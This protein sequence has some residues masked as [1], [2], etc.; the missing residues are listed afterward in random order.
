[1]NYLLQLL[2]LIDIYVILALSLNLLVGYTGLLSLSQAAFYGIGAY[3]SAILML[4]LGMGFPMAL[5]SAVI[6][7]VLLSLLISLPSLRLKGDY[8]I[9]ASLGF[10]VIIFT[11]LLNW[12]NLTG[13]PNG[14]KGIPRP[15]F[16]GLQFNTTE[17]YFAFCSVVTLTCAGLFYLLG[18]SPFGR[19]LKGIREDE[20]AMSALGKNIVLLK[21]YVFAIAAGFAAIAGALFAGHM[22]T[23][24]PSS[25]NITESIFILSMIILGGTGNFVGPVVGTIITILLPEILSLLNVPNA[26]NLR[27]IIFGLLIILL[28]RFRPEGLFGEY[29]FE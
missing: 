4:N 17:M 21:I 19:L 11:L 8:F 28:L 1:M 13:G 25:F 24:E 16:L 6:F 26:A 5:I 15:Q 3:A 2:T 20:I 14:I 12:T 7:T 27:E 18:N 10:Q 23:L 9:L 29:K 22:R